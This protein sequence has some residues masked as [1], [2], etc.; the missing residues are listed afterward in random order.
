MF[1]LGLLAVAI[2][3]VSY[4]LYFRDI[5][6]GR[7]KPH[8]LTWLIWSILNSVVFYQQLMAGAGPGAWVTGA[9]AVANLLIFVASFW[10]GE[11]RITRFDWVCLVLALAAVM[12]LLYDPYP[13]ASVTVVSAVF[14]IGMIPTLRKSLYN[15]HEETAVT[16]ALNGIKF[17]IALFALQVLSVTTVL[18]PLVLC[19]TNLLF[20]AFLFYQQAKYRR[21]SRE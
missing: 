2:A 12:V 19:I 10:Y 13:V 21:A 20:A 15:A 7:T 8:A 14:V 1:S 3:I 16:F 17:L 5:F 11:R 4:G 18:Y 9:A 6:A